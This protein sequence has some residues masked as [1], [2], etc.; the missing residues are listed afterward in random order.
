[1]LPKKHFLI[2]SNK[3]QIKRGH[4]ILT[5]DLLNHLLKPS[6]GNLDGNSLIRVSTKALSVK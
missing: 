5:Q 1:M 2:R 3:I 4:F 6:Y